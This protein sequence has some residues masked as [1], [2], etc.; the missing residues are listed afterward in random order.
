MDH[1]EE[2]EEDRNNIPMPAIKGR[3]KYDNL[4]FRFKNT[5]PLQ[6]KNVTTEFDPGTFVAIV[7]ESGAGKST[8]TKL[9]SPPI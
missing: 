4:S 6:L 5:G 8:M 2:G 1:P 9:L 3:V 7:G